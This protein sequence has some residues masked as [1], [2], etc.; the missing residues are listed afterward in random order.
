MTK[1]IPWILLSGNWNE[2]YTDVRIRLPA[3]IKKEKI[4]E[5]LLLTGIYLSIY[6]SHTVI[7]WNKIFILRRTR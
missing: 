7:I 3:S 1:N 4:V 5:K 2:I 6:Q